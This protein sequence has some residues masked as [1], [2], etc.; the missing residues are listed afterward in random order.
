M[1][2]RGIHW[3]K[4][5]FP[6]KESH[7]SPFWWIL[8]SQVSLCCKVVMKHM[9]HRQ[10]FFALFGQ[11]WW[12]GMT[13]GCVC[14]FSCHLECNWFYFFCSILYSNSLFV[15]HLWKHP[16]LSRVPL[17]LSLSSFPPLSRFHQFL[18]APQPTVWN[19]SSLCSLHFMPD[20][21]PAAFCCSSYLLQDLLLTTAS[22]FCCC[23]TGFPP[24]S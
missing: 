19:R 8:Q 11:R 24:S 10:G 1:L 6:K 3:Y 22:I 5:K 23:V 17:V 20:L 13:E 16:P 14:S 2:Q 18:N 7:H 4:I 9:M 12:E 15:F 21:S